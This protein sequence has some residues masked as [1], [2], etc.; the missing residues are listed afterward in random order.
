MEGA[1]LLRL[2]LGLFTD[3]GASALAR[4]A[5]EV[6]EGPLCAEGATQRAHGVQRYVGVGEKVEQGLLDVRNLL[7]PVQRVDDHLARRAVPVGPAQLKERG[8]VLGGRCRSQRVAQ[9]PACSRRMVLGPLLEGLQQRGE[10]S[11]ACPWTS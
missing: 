9:V 4:D 5:F 8:H 1:R 3:E 7:E 2:A 11:R 10:G 6:W